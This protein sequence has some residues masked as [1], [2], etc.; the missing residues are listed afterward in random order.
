MKLIY[1]GFRTEVPKDRRLFK[2]EIET[3]LTE[4]S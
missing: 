1:V 3:S 2:E 4:L